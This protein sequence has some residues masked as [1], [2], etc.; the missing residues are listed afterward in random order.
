MLLKFNVADDAPKSKKFMT[1]M[2][3]ISIPF[4]TDDGSRCLVLVAG[5]PLPKVKEIIV[6]LE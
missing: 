2:E 4:M 1:E 6:E 3:S 5:S